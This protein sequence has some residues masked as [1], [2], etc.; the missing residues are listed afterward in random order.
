MRD[1]TTH[2]VAGG[3]PFE[4]VSCTRDRYPTQ[5]LAIAAAIGES[6]PGDTVEIHASDCRLSAIEDPTPDDEA[7]CGCVPLVITVGATA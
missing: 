6:E 3:Y 1:P 7:A 5:E 2:Y 4:Q